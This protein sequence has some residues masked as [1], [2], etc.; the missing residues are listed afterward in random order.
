MFSSRDAVPSSPWG[1][2]AAPVKVHSAARARWK[3]ITS[4]AEGSARLLLLL[5]HMEGG[6]WG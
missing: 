5:R 4:W 2:A 6:V 1:C 3:E